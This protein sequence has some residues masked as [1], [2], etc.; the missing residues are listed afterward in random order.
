[1]RAVGLAA[2]AADASLEQHTFL[3]RFRKATEFNP[4]NIVSG[5]PSARRARCWN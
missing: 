5:Y 3:R 2:M 4:P 1:M